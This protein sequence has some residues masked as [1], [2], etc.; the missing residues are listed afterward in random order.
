MADLDGPRC[1]ASINTAGNANQAVR[2]CTIEW[3]RTSCE[4]PNAYLAW[5]DG[6]RQMRGSG[7]HEGIA[8]EVT[9]DYADPQPGTCP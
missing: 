1:E 8:Y 2:Y 7:V 5:E 4:T 6:I 9:P 3:L